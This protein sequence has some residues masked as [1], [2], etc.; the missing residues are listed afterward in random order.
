MGLGD[1]DHP[2][3]L[4]VAHVGLDDDRRAPHV[5][6]LDRGVGCALAHGTDLP[7]ASVVGE[8]LIVANH[9]FYDFDAKYLHAE[10]VVLQ[11]PAEVPEEVAERIR[12]LS[13]R[14]FL[15]AGCEGLARVAVARMATAASS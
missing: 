13:V 14:A 11:T 10:D 6:R 2:A 15:A 3:T 4:V 12:E 9:E 8:C 7:R 5:E 1:Q